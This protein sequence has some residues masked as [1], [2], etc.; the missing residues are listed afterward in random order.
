MHASMRFLAAV[1]AGAGLVA[2]T[3]QQASAVGG[4]PAPEGA[5]AFTARIQVGTAG[6][7]GH[8]CSG[9]LIDP[10]WIATARD[11]FAAPGQPLPSGT[12]LAAATVTLGAGAHTSAITR[13]VAHPDRAVVLARLAKPATTIKPAAIGTRAPASGDVVDAAGYGRTHTEWIPD[14]VHHAAYTVTAVDATTVTLTARDEAGGGICRGDAGGPTLRGSGDAVEVVAL[15][16]GSDQAGCLGERDGRNTATDI[17]LD[18]LGGWIVTATTERLRH[19]FNGDGHDDVAGHNSRDNMELFLGSSAGQLRSGGL[20][21]QG[22]GQWAGFHSVT[23]G[24]FDNDGKVDVAGHNSRNNMELFLGDGAGK[25]RS[26][27][28]MWAEGGEWAGFKSI[29]AGDFDGDGNLDIAGINSNNDMELFPGNGRGRLREGPLMWPRG[30][31]WAGFHSIAAGDFN[32]DGKLDIAGHNSRNNMELF[33]GDGTGQL[34]SGGLMW[35]EG[36][37]WAGFKEITAGDFDD[38]GNL[39]IAGIN[40]N[41]DM[42]LFPGNGQGRLREGPL[43]WPRGGQWAGFHSLTS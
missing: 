22:G 32:N 6:S 19:D 13:L 28:L 16:S 1:L 24:D 18:D 43:M 2:A 40:S 23:S 4:S 17:R 39:D 31:Q 25:L 33:L 14:R 11:C 9:V 34:R 41:N 15:H 27:G 21:W 3:A 10:R 20:M 35:A 37:E 12:A 7:G 26:G 42:E 29:T 5:Y 36:G 8:A 30:G 38:D